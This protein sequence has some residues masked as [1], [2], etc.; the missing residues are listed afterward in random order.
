VRA[1]IGVFS[2]KKFSLIFL[3]KIFDFPIDNR[4]KG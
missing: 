1:I 3:K 4:K 2:T